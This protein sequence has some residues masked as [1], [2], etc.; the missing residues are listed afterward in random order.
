MWFRCSIALP[1]RTATDASPAPSREPAHGSRGNVARLGLR[2]GELPPPALCQFAWHTTSVHPNARARDVINAWA[3]RG[4]HV[5]GDGRAPVGGIG[6]PIAR[7]AMLGAQGDGGIQVD[8]AAAGLL[9]C[10]ARNEAVANR[11]VQACGFGRQRPGVR[12][13]KATSW[14]AAPGRPLRA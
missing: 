13:W 4:R 9:D 2:F 3:T 1:V 7:C 5:C 10:Q 8:A 11:L 12:L 6:L 14:P